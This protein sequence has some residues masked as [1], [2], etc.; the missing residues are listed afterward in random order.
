MNKW[1]TANGREFEIWQ[2][3]TSHLLNVAKLIALKAAKW[4]EGDYP[5]D[6][7]ISADSFL[8]GEMA[9][10]TFESEFFGYYDPQEEGGFQEEFEWGLEQDEFW[11]PVTDEL[12]RRME[13]NSTFYQSSE[14]VR[15][16]IN[17]HLEAAGMNCSLGVFYFEEK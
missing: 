10:D 2:M 7:A 3:E 16:I 13:V 11:G 8:T 5:L 1:V 9:R 12:I 17:K 4:A 6:L 14:K 15:S